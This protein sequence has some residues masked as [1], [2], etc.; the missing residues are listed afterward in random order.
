MDLWKLEEHGKDSKIIRAYGGHSCD[1]VTTTT[2]TTCRNLEPWADVPSQ[3]WNEWEKYMV[4]VGV[5]DIQGCRFAPEK[6]LGKHSRQR[7]YLVPDLNIGDCRVWRLDSGSNLEPWY[8]MV[9]Q[10]FCWYMGDLFLDLWNW[11]TI[12]E[13]S[14]SW[15]VL[16]GW[17]LY[18][19][20][21]GSNNLVSAFCGVSHENDS[22]IP[23][24]DVMYEKIAADTM[25]DP[26]QQAPN[27]SRG[28]G[29][30]KGRLRLDPPYVKVLLALQ[31][32]ITSLNRLWVM[33]NFKCQRCWCPSKPTRSYASV[34]F[35][36]LS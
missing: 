2:L 16:S 4:R 5:T 18:G 36:L 11:I 33:M 30:Q 19:N 35:L 8:L 23:R 17:I 14:Y 12:L 3:A 10:Y 26:W 22:D 31:R 34:P 1:V 13:G 29:R 25:M 24:P 21:F 27:S 15:Q 9:W 28:D 20:I 6:H 7:W 32:M